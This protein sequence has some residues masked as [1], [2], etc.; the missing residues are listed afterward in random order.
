MHG[1]SDWVDVASGPVSGLLAS[2]AFY[3]SQTLWTAA[4]VA[5]AVLMGCGAIWAALRAAHPRRRLTYATSHAPLIHEPVGGALEIRCNGTLLAD[6]H[7]VRIVLTNPGRRDIPSGAFD[8]GQPIRVDLGVPYVELV[9]TEAEPSAAEPPPVTLH[10]SE[11]RIGPGLIGCGT[12]VTC[13]LLV[14]TPPTCRYRH[15]LLDVKVEQIPLPAA[16][17][18]AVMRPAPLVRP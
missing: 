12:T 9:A 6:P 14:D 10:G 11:L 16:S 2:G 4:G 3:A 13:L 1:T 7:L 5:V 18:W 15:S 17:R 8:R